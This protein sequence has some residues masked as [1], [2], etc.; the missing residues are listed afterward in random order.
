MLSPTHC[1]VRG[2]DLWDLVEEIERDAPDPYAARGGRVAVGA[3]HLGA[4]QLEIVLN[5]SHR[6]LHTV[7][8]EL[9]RQRHRLG[10]AAHAD[11]PVARAEV[12]PVSAAGELRSR[13]SGQQSRADECARV[14]EEVPTGGQSASHDHHLDNSPCFTRF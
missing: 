13:L 4:A 10:L 2:S 9:P 5:N 7:E 3:L 6:H 1:S 14:L 8:A 12:E 11:R